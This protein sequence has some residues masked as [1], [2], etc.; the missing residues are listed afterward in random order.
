MI[1]N[2]LLSKY[3][4][5]SRAYLDAFAREAAQAVPAGGK[6]LDAGAGDCRYSEFFV[7]AGY[8]SADFCQ[9]EKPYGEITHVCDLAH[10]PVEAERYDVVFCT[11]T[12][13]HIRVPLN[14][15]EE[16]YR[17]LKP[18]GQLWLTA[19]LYYE[20]HE[21]PHDYFRYTKFGLAALLEQ[22]GFAV[23]RLD[24]LEGY[25]G[26]LAYQLRL[27]ACSLPRHPWFYG[28]G[29]TGVMWA[30]VIWLGRPLCALLSALFSRLDVKRKVTFAGHAINYLVVAQR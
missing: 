3:R 30:A 27:A 29:I 12:L 22:A 17:V 23:K 7:A 21:A 24:W 2:Y 14:V 6:V 5:S 28:R 8:E 4:N 10:I 20:E 19:P 1:T 15:L 13:E 18:G 11:Q 9:V 26:T 25:Y 16:F